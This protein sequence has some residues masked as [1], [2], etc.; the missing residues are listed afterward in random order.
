MNYESIHIL[1]FTNSILVICPTL[2]CALHVQCMAL[3]CFRELN[4]LTKQN[5]PIHCKFYFNLLQ[6]F[7]PIEVIRLS[8]SLE[9]LESLEN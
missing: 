4:K 2:V 7:V 1:Y 8:Q 9:S 6:P 3:F 5:S